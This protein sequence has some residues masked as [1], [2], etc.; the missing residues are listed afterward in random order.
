MLRHDLIHHSTGK[1]PKATLS[2]VKADLEDDYE[3]L[4]EEERNMVS[5]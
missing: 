5:L 2:K 3:T 4:Q 1:I